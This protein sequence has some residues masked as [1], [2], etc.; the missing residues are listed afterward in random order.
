MARRSR[1]SRHITKKMT[2]GFRCA[3][4]FESSRRTAIEH[5]STLFSGRGSDI[6]NPIGTTNNIELVFNNEKRISRSLQAIER[7]QQCFCVR[8]MDPADGS[9]S[10]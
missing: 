6:Y 3:D 7:H 10:T 4:A 2:T 8:G 1:G 5:L 9:S